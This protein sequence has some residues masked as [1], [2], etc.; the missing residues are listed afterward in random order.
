MFAI[1]GQ[2]NCA[3]ANSQKCLFLFFFNAPNTSN[4]ITVTHPDLYFSFLEMH[5]NFIFVT[6]NADDAIY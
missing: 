5:I 3:T 4:L 1:N 6:N 2:I